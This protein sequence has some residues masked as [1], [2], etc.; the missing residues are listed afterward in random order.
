MTFDTVEKCRDQLLSA[1]NANKIWYM[2]VYVKKSNADAFL[3]VFWFYNVKRVYYF[4]GRLNLHDLIVY[5]IYI[6]ISIAVRVI[7]YFLTCK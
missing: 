7:R 5:W 2:I 4:N 6:E 1:R 3:F